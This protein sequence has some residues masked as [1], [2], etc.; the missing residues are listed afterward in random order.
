MPLLAAV[1]K[2]FD[3]ID[4]RNS[5]QEMESGLFRISIPAYDRRAVRESVVTAFSHRDY[6]QLGRV[7]VQIDEDGL[8]VSNPDGF[9]EGVTVQ[10]I[11]NAEPCGRNPVLADTLKRIGLAE[12]AGRG[13]RWQRSFKIPIFQRLK[14]VIR[15]SV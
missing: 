8:T 4:A 1:E 14:C 2:I 11:L 6:T 15:W 13:C 9:I 3:F 7:L 10:N 12:R 5:V